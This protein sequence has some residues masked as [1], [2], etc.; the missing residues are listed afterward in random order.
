MGI[1]ATLALLAER[2]ERLEKA[3]ENLKPKSEEVTGL[4]TTAQAGELLACSDEYI[5]M[6]QDRGDLELI[7]LP[8]SNRRRVLKSEL[9][10]L[11][12]K[13]KVKRSKK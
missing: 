8:G 2:S 4:L 5:R 7:F 11:I 12:E 13:S 9:L 6:L 1:E 3:L 10:A